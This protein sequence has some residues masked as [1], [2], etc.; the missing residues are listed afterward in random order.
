MSGN[1]SAK[2]GGA[3]EGDSSELDGVSG[4]DVE[5]EEVRYPVAV[6]VPGTPASAVFLL[7]PPS[8]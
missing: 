3:K 7:L 8:L 2:S 6:R 5:D 1:W 4:G